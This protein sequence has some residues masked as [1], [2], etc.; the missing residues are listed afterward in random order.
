MDDKKSSNENNV[1]EK[2][3]KDTE[4]IQSSNNSNIKEKNKFLRTNYITKIALFSALAFKI[5][6]AHV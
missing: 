4:I 2:K 6:R 1:T 5:G 3:D